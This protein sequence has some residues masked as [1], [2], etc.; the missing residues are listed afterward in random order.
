MAFPRLSVA[1]LFIGLLS[2]IGCNGRTPT[3]T[4]VKEAE[5]GCAD[6]FLFKAMA[7]Q[8]EWLWVSA[9]KKKLNLPD[10]GSKTFDLADELDGLMVK[11]DLWSGT[12]KFQPYCNCVRG[13]E[14]VD[15]TWTARSGKVTITIQEPL[16]GEGPLKRYK[17]SAKLEGV[18]FENEA[19]QR[20]TLQQ[21]TITEVLCGWYAG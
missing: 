4:Y 18:V 13:G 8:R 10:K 21:E 11:I 15:A 14:N 2:L 5:G 19:G 1:L 16:P 17:V 3:L 12:P 6:V 9:D 20:L 7:D